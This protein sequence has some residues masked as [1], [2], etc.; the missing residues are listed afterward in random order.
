MVISLFVAGG[1][2]YVIYVSWKSLVSPW[3]PESDRLRSI[4]TVRIVQSVSVAIIV[5]FHAAGMAAGG[6]YAFTVM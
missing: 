1:F 6:I 2:A 4:A 3:L 5:L